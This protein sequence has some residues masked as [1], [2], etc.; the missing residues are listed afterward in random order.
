MRPLLY[1]S[2]GIAL[3]TGTAAA[4]PEPGDVFREYVW[5]GP[6]VNAANWQRV[7]DP[8]AAHKG[9]KQFLPNPVNR[10]TIDD[11]DAAVRVE[12]CLE[13]WGGHAGTS[14][15][16]MRVNGG[17]WLP[18]P[19]SPRIGPKRPEAYQYF[20]YPCVAVPLQRVK[21]GENTFAFTCGGQI[22]HDFGWGQW[23]VYGVTFR[24]YYDPA[25]K[26]HPTGRVTAP[27]DGDRV[28][29]PVT[30]TAE[31][32]APPGRSVRS[33]DFIGHYDDFNWEGDGLY[34]QWHYT[35]RYGKIQ[36]HL[37]TAGAAPWTVRWDT[38]WV[39][40]QPRPMRVC[41]RLTD[42]AGVSAMTPAVEGIRLV[43]RG[44]SVRLYPPQDV[45]TGWQTRAG[46]THECKVN[47][48]G[49]LSKAVAARMILVTWCG[50]HA[51]AVG[52]NGRKVVAKVGR[53]HDYSCDAIPVPVEWIRPGV[54]TLYTH[55]TTEHHGIEVQW[56]G[57]AL[58]VQYEA[59]R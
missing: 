44:R 53:N 9:A 32:E 21:E 55:A 43:R 2:V 22:A 27:A 14:E 3:L 49:D 8:D 50:T 23:G 33:V 11:L 47:V 28:T 29:G 7:T 4:R 1:V 45:P 40:D 37:G 10:I 20:R 41:A 5:T 56:P 59:G 39:P 6:W 12:V 26:P 18:V 58:V 57:I 24:V 19:E 15:K 48:T 30:L 36:H 31:A 13:Q 46:K 34:R 35:Y 25:R 16:R 38:A 51:D 52:I 54:N 17:P 42:S